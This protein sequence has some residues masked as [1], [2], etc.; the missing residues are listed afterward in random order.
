VDCLKFC[1]EKFGRYLTARDIEGDTPLHISAICDWTD[2]IETIC[3]SIPDPILRKEIVNMPNNAGRIALHTSADREGVSSMI[4]LLNAGSNIFHR[5][6]AGDLPLHLAARNRSTKCL[7]IL[8]DWNERYYKEVDLAPG[9]N[10][11]QRSWVDR[12]ED[13]KQEFQKAFSIVCYNKNVRGIKLLLKAGARPT[14]SDSIPQFANSNT[15]MMKILINT[16]LWYVL[17]MVRNEFLRNRFHN[18]N[19]HLYANIY[20][21]IYDNAIFRSV[22]KYM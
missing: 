18:T 13:T 8:L 4:A 12:Q 15:E 7:K 16:T 1:I 6:K 3:N 5:D 22:K 20:N 19:T 10:R 11:T 17:Y 21:N 2:G 9:P 14:F